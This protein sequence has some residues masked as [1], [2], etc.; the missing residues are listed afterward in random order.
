MNT[1]HCV[2]LK[3]ILVTTA[4]EKCLLGD[5]SRDSD[6]VLLLRL[7]EV[8]SINQVVLDP[9]RPPVF[10]TQLSCLLIDPFNTLIKM[11]QHIY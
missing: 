8:S 4:D 10:C 7:E 1:G 11:Q 2:Q 5:F 6:K 3:Y 9:P